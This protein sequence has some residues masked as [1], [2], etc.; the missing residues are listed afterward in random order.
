MLSRLLQQP[1]QPR[2]EAMSSAT[3]TPG[4]RRRLEAGALGTEME[5]APAVINVEE[6]PNPPPPPSSWEG[7]EL[8]DGRLGGLLKDALYI[9]M[10]TAY[11]KLPFSKAAF[12]LT[13]EQE[14]QFAGWQQ[15]H[16]SRTLVSLAVPL[17]ERLAMVP[18]DLEVHEAVFRSLAQLNISLDEL[19]ASRKC[20]RFIHF[21]CFWPVN[22]YLSYFFRLG[23][24]PGRGLTLPKPWFR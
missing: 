4:K 19:G 7:V 1:Q 12:F 8:A 18:K 6:M 23:L 13:E 15:G 11:P 22:L 16:S 10:G 17:K 5:P 2:P 21:F 9:E 14:A 24:R 20:F 3:P